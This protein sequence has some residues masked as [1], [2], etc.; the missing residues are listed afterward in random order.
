MSRFGESWGWNV[1]N[2]D[3]HTHSVLEM[4]GKIKKIKK[5]LT[6]EVKKKSENIFYFF[7]Y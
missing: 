6:R 4:G 7:K 2:D 3:I 5:A 1:C